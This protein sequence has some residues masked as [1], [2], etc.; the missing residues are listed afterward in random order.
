MLPKGTF[1][2]GNLIRF[3]ILYFNNK[4]VFRALDAQPA[5]E[6]WAMGLPVDPFDRAK[7]EI[8]TFHDNVS[9][10]DWVIYVDPATFTQEEYQQIIS[11]YE[12]HREEIDSTLENSKF[13]PWWTQKEKPPRSFGFDYHAQRISHIV[14][15]A[16]P[17]PQIF[18][19]QK[20]SKGYL[21]EGKRIPISSETLT[22]YPNGQWLIKVRRKEGII[23]PWNDHPIGEGEII[24]DDTEKIFNIKWLKFF[25]LDSIKN[26][27]VYEYFASLVDSH[28]NKLTDFY[29]FGN[30]PSKFNT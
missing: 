16:M 15:G 17:Q 27:S 9:R 5:P 14:Y 7:L 2:S 3:P 21:S 19:P 6:L 22:I 23:S 25:D 26:I 29:R 1:S 8:K 12:V 11:C 30:I 24:F 13:T 10:S 20:I 4:I 18:S 28:G